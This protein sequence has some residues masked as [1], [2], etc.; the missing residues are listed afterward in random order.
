MSEPKY[1]LDGRS[2]KMKKGINQWAFPPS[3]SLREVFQLAQRY[4]FHGVE[5]CPDEEGPASLSLPLSGWREIAAIAEEVGVGI[6]SLACG[7]FWKYNLVSG[8][9]KVRLKAREIVKRLIEIAQVVRAKSVLVIP[10]YVNVPWDPQSEIV[11]YDFAME[12]A[13][14]ALSELAP[15]AQGTQVFLGVENVWNKF[16]LSPLEFRDFIDSIGNPFVKAHFDTGNVLISGYPEQWIHILK[17]RIVTVHVKDFKISV[18]NIN[19]FCLPLEGDVD[20]PQVM[21]ALKS[22]GYGD[23]LIAEFIPP[24]RHSFEALLAN[25][26]SN[27]DCIMEMG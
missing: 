8:E 1:F 12:R 18:G 4:G 9:E 3:L 21:S 14:E 7:L 15:L 26:S 2:K 5:L 20:W 22:I 19:G 27:L 25:L 23:Y 16:L 6:R 11:S 10:G 24:Y 13:R 17:E